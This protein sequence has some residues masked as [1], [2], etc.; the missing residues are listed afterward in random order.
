MDLSLMRRL[1]KDKGGEGNRCV[2]RLGDGKGDLKMGLQCGPS[3]GTQRGY[4][5]MTR[6]NYP[7]AMCI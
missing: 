6:S 5:Y 1:L 3:R 4:L 7:I 2:F